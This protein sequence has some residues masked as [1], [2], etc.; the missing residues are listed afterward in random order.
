[1]IQL[2]KQAGAKCICVASTKEKLDICTKLGA[3]FVINYKENPDY[4]HLVKEFTNGRG[5]DIIADPVGASNAARNIDALAVDGRWVCFGMLGGKEVPNFNMGA[6]LAKRG[7]LH[8]TLLKSRS[9]EY[10]A[11]LL[12]QMRAVVFESGFGFEPVLHKV[13][14]MSEARQAHEMM[15]ANET[16]GK[17]LLEYDL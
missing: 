12:A 7:T 3:D 4:Q 5:A 8:T 13:F 1:M 16:I 6:L 9:V 2:C 17:I 11:K 10:K 14:K 15:E